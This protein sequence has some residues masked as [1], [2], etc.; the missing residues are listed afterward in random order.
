MA[1]DEDSHALKGVFQAAFEL[2]NSGDLAEHEETE[3]TEAMDWLK[4]HL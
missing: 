2:R 3:L 1:K 4:Q